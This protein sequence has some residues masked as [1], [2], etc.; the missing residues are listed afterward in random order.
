MKT[1]LLTCLAIFQLAC[2]AQKPALSSS[3]IN[4]E[5]KPKIVVGIVVDQMRDDYLYRFYDK[6]SEG[7]FKRMM[8]QGFNA[9][10]HHYHYASTVTG[11]GHAHIYTGPIPAMSGI[12]GNERHE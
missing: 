5:G 6:Y 8:N 1:A 2:T 11:H 12:V 7:G 10:N 3:Q 9:R 4:T